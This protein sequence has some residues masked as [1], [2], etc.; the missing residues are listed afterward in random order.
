MES[1]LREAESNLDI[2]GYVNPA[3]VEEKGYTGNI[4]QLEDLITINGIEELIF[5]AADMSTQEII[6]QMVRLTNGRVRYKIAPP[7]SLSIIGSHS[8][9]TPGDIYLIDFESIT[10]KSNRRVKRLFDVL[11]ALLLLAF[12]PVLVFTVRNPGQAFLN[13]L[14]VLSGRYSW[15]G[16]HPSPDRPRLPSIRKGILFPSDALG[17]ED[18]P[19]DAKDSLNL[20]YVK[21]YSVF[22]DAGILMRSIRQIGRK[23]G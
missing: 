22:T 5:C 7:A 20:L 16:F 10:K 13:I 12:Y 14:H 15:V 18:I 19:Q 8:I 17:G 21:N 1:L 11:S 2:V 3:P 23:R 6:G 9:N 4:T